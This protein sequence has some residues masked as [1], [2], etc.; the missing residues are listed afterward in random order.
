M[1]A[2]NLLNER[3]FGMTNLDLRHTGLLGYDDQPPLNIT[4]GI[5]THFWTGPQTLDLPPQLY[6]VYMDL[7]WQPW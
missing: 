4:P 7:Q 1:Q 5:G 6:D 2:G 3:G